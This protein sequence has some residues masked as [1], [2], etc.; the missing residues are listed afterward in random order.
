MED[1]ENIFRFRIDKELDEAIGLSP[2]LVTNLNDEIGLIP[3][4]SARV[5]RSPLQFFQDDIND[6]TFGSQIEPSFDDS[7]ILNT[8]FDDF[9]DPGKMNALDVVSLFTRVNRLEQALKDSEKKLSQA[10]QR[11]EDLEREL[12]IR[13]D[14]LRELNLSINDIAL[15]DQKLAER[16]ERLAQTFRK[17][18]FWSNL[19]LRNL[20]IFFF[21]LQL[22]FAVL[23]FSNFQDFFSSSKLAEE[24]P[25]PPLKEL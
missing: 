4:A 9:R 11:Q 12:R 1:P 20:V 2:K 17:L 24:N 16:M 5:P 8:T 6:E 22:V 3:K 23:L 18:S 19:K 14:Q 7:I 25:V 21:L 15:E 10:I 13:E